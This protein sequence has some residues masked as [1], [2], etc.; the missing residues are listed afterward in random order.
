VLAVVAISI[1]CPIDRTFNTRK[2]L[3]DG[4][5]RARWRRGDPNPSREL[6]MRKIPSLLLIA[7]LGVAGGVVGTA[8]SEEK[9]PAALAR[10]LQGAKATLAGGLQAS[11]R[12]GQPISGKFE[13]EDGKLQL[14]VYTLKGSEFMEVVLDPATG[15]IAKAEKITDADDLKAATDQKAAMAKAKRSLRA[16]TES[17]LTANGGTRAVSILPALKDGHPVGEV[18]LQQGDNIKKVTAPLD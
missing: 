12:E 3:F 6:A 9:D 7:L 2:D 10:A 17:T 5:G 11:E 13:I 15:A 16:A 4:S 18:T 8:S 14:S 1:A